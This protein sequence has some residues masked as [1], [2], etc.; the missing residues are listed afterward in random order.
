MGVLGVRIGLFGHPLRYSL[1]STASPLLC[2]EDGGGGI[3]RFRRDDVRRHLP[4]HTLR[5]RFALPRPPRFA[6][7]TV[8][9]GF[10]AFAGMTCAGTSPGTPC[11]VASLAASPSLR[12]GE[13][14]GGI[15][16]GVRGDVSV[17]VGL[18]ESLP[19]LPNAWARSSG[20]R[21]VGS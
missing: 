8:E 18:V 6:K 10:A 13:G 12:E 19:R 16:F 4:G 2:E 21:A 9:E 20:V 11:G 7:G 5:R 14:G 3:R 1:R 17:G 15:R